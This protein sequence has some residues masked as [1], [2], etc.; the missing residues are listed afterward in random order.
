MNTE[1]LMT[2]IR[3]LDKIVLP[4]PSSTP[5]ENA[6]VAAFIGNALKLGF[7]FNR[8]AYQHIFQADA[9]TLEHVLTV[10]QQYRG[11]QYEYEPMYP[12]FPDQVAKASEIELL[13][14]AMMHYLGDYIGGLRIM[15]Q[16]VKALRPELTQFDEITVLGVATEEELSELFQKIAHYSQPFGVTEHRDLKALAEYATATRVPVKENAVFL[17]QRFPQLDWS[18]N[19]QTVTDVLRLAVAWSDGDITLAEPYRF[20][21]SRPQRR[22][23]VSMLEKVITSSGNVVDDF[24]KYQERWKVLAHHLHAHHYAAYAPKAFEM[25]QHVQQDTLGR[26]YNSFV[27]E[28]IDTHDLD[29]A[30][31]LL[32]E[33]PGVFARRLHEL[34]RKF[35]A[36]RQIVVQGFAAVAHRVAPNVLIQMHN[37]FGSADKTIVPHR[38]VYIKSRHGKNTTKAIPNTLEGDYDDVLEMV[39]QGLAAQ[40]EE[41]KIFF[42]GDASQYAVPLGVRSMSDS[43]HQIARGSRVSVADSDL[44][45]NILRLFMHWKNPDDYTRVDLDLSVFFIDEDFQKAETVAYYNLRSEDLAYHSGDITSAPDGAS[46]FIDVD[47]EQALLDGYRYV[48]PSVYNYTRQPFNVVDEAL[49]G[50]MLREDMN[51]GEIYDP[52]TVRHT[53]LLENQTSN[54]V[55]F[56]FDLKTRTMIWVDSTIRPN[57]DMNYNVANNVN[58][59]LVLLKTMVH[60]EAMTVEQFAQ[61]VGEIVETEDQATHVVHPGRFEDIAQLFPSA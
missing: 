16:Y 36:S 18:A 43:T 34:L 32:S 12:N 8:N 24:L 38:L 27:Q 58:A 20:K 10:L 39:E 7:G 2:T 46:E 6:L 15:P 48:V 31:A 53:Y 4:E 17:A 14:N 1:L 40:S 42:H 51:S 41:A 47:M 55:P 35:P 49:T 29:S 30:V 19:F 59:F 54:S 23:I 21:L 22:T 3:R 44:D 28:A 45:K 50:F 11:A 52:K 61:L 25:L 33:R 60:S 9:K 37:F 13:V 57:T 26:S 5:A 56:I